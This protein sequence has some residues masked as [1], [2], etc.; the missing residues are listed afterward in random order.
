MYRRVQPPVFEG[1]E[2]GDYPKNG[3][4]GSSDFSLSGA[5]PHKPWFCKELVKDAGVKLVIA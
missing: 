3:G 2:W 1:F 5:M 4:T